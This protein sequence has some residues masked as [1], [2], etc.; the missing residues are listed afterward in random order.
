MKTKEESRAERSS[1]GA[2]EELSVTDAHP[3]EKIPAD[4]DDDTF[5]EAE[6][7]ANST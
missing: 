3:D 5:S 1:K 7:G 4:Y 2:K 6:T